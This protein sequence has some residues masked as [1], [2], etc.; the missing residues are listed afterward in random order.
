MEKKAKKNISENQSGREII[1]VKI[2]ASD[3]TEKERDMYPAVCSVSLSYGESESV[4][5]NETALSL[6]A[7]D[8]LDDLCFRRLQ[9]QS[10]SA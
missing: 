1:R 2:I 3:S 10:K 8:R 5:Q 7:F 9:G 4:R 6:I